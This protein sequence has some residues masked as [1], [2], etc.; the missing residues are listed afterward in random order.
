LLLHDSQPV[1]KK[2]ER[3]KQYTFSSQ[4]EQRRE[5]YCSP[6]IMM[7]IGIFAKT[8]P[9]TLEQCLDAVAAYGCRIIQFNFSC[10]GP[11][12][13]SLPDRIEDAVAQRIR[14]ETERRGITIAA[15][16]GTFNMIA[17]DHAKRQ[18]GLRRLR[19]LADTCHAIGTA[20]I[21]LC[22]GTRDPEDMWQAHPANASPEAW[23][24]LIASMHE[25]LLI[26]EQYNL[27]LGIEPE[28]ANVVS[29]AQAAYR[30]LQEMQ[31]PRLKIIIDP[32]NLFHGGDLPYMHE[33]LDRAFDL[34]GSEIVLA[35][36]KD[37][38]FDGQAIHHVAAGKGLLDYEYYLGLL[39][40]IRT[41]NRSVPMILHGL[42]VTEVKNSLEFLRTTIH[43]VEGAA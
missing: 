20:M 1:F 22:T 14:Q 32:A 39:Q 23:T 5:V 18:A 25:A 27:I 28:T 4:L 17:P 13:P 37:V 33:V 12:A 30:L 10:L 29:S 11:G 3:K 31:S 42:Q 35:H 24:D 38:S 16:S 36:A 8:F 41:Q 26:A 34:L 15:V 9:G 19:V 40:S 43:K 21:T 7:Q 6:S 2:I